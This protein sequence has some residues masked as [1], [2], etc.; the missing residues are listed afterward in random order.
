LQ[1]FWN[2]IAGTI[3]PS[4]AGLAVVGAVAILSMP[5]E[6]DAHLFAGGAAS[7]VLSLHLLNSPVR[8]DLHQR[9]IYGHLGSETL[10]EMR[11]EL[12][13]L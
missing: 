7:L 6:E 9:G 1:Q 8:S 5:T 13:A 3:M 11:Q 2:Y 4:A 12:S 10:A